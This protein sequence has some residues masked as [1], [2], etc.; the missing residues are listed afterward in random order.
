MSFIEG[1]LLG[2]VPPHVRFEGGKFTGVDYVELDRR[3][4]EA[5]LA[6]L[7]FESNLGIRE[8][9]QISR[10]IGESKV[11]VVP[12]EKLPNED[13][14]AV[15]GKLVAVEDKC[16]A[17]ILVDGRKYEAINSSIRK[18]QLG[19]AAKKL[20]DLMVEEKKR[21]GELVPVSAPMVRRSLAN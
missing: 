9:G 20:H 8:A 2:F 17:V 18:M 3:L 4:K 6:D 11:A 15:I 1:K 10:E 13:K 19:K 7:A 16:A 12:V 5:V 14:K 21:G